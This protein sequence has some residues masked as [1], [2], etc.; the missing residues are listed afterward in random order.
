MNDLSE[1]ELRTVK[2]LIS[3]GD[4]EELAIKTVIEARGRHSEEAKD[5][6]RL[7]YQ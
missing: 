2:S 7:A 4:S 3:L 1:K 6:Y 5:M